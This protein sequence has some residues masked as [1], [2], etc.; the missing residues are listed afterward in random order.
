M[1]KRQFVLGL[2]GSLGLIAHVMAV[3]PATESATSLNKLPKI[4]SY[5][6]LV[7]RVDLVQS[8]PNAI[9]FGLGESLINPQLAP[10]LTWNAT[11]LRTFSDA[12]IKIS[13]NADDYKNA[14]QNSKLAMQRAVNIRDA[15]LDMGVSDQ[16][17]DVVSL[18]DRAPKFKKDSDGHQPRNQ[19]VDLFYTAK[20]PKG[21]EVEKVPV[22][23]TDS[24]QQEV[25]PEPVN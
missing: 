20:A 22:V 17:M 19:R 25:V 11:Y 9:V 13:G 24:Y 3:T 21:Y 8:M 2:I 15:L 14:V 16:Q 1:S 12:K 18:G 7:E 6:V 23:K 4:E 10:I 5:P